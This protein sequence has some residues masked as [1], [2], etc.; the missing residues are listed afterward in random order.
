MTAYT[1]KPLKWEKRDNIGWETADT[2]FC[3]YNIV[4]R[5]V[6]S[7]TVTNGRS[8]Y[9]MSLGQFATLREAK[10]EAEDHYLQHMMMCLEEV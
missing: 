9:V 10:S 4:C 5:D 8:D 7:V 3:R 6:F 1:I 2:G